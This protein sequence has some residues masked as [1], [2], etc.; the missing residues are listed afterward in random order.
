L[1]AQGNLFLTSLAA[2]CR[3]KRDDYKL[4]CWSCSTDV[5]YWL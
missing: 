1:T 5:V 4:F 2:N 3:C